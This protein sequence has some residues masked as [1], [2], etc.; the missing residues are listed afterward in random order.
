MHIIIEKIFEAKDDHISLLDATMHIIE[1][2][3]LPIREVGK[4]LKK[5]KP[6]LKMLKKESQK[7]NIF[8]E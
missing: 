7:L 4:I 5:N 8:S 6:F 2:E 1:Q 3:N